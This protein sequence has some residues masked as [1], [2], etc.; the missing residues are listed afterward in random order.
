ME[1]TGKRVEFLKYACGQQAIEEM[2][3]L[4]ALRVGD[5]GQVDLLVVVYKDLGKG[6]QLVQLGAG[7]GNVPCGTLFLQPLFVDHSVF[8]SVRWLG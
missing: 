3:V 4:D 6:I 7:E 2:L 8:L 1:P 5:G